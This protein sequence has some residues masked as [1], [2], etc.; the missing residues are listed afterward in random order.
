MIK[1]LVGLALF[2]VVVTACASTT[3]PVAPEPT[4]SLTTFDLKAGD[5]LEFE[6]TSSVLPD[7]ATLSSVT[8]I[9]VTGASGAQVLLREDISY[10]MRS[11]FL[12]TYHG[13]EAAQ[14]IAKFPTKAGDT[15]IHS[16]DTLMDPA[17]KVLQIYDEVVIAMNADTTIST[18]V[19]TFRCA[20]FRSLSMPTLTDGVGIVVT[21]TLSYVS[22]TLGI[23]TNESHQWAGTST[24]GPPFGSSTSKLV[25]IIR[26]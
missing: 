10:R 23:I 16:L 11:G 19:G 4:F 25:K 12:E 15:V 8:V 5:K 6:S 2:A 13:T 7:S 1:P 17:G 21:Q 26:K 14:V 3:D 9:G 18:P 20:A 24:D 22:P